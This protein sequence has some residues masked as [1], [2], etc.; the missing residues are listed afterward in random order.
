MQAGAGTIRAL[1]PLYTVEPPLPIQRGHAQ[2]HFDT[3]E[4]HRDG[5]VY[6]G[7]ESN[8]IKGEYLPSGKIARSSSTLGKLVNIYV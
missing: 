2:G 7:Y 3:H 8:R 6:V 5:I 4:R 1:V